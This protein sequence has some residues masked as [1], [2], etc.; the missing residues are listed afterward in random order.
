MSQATSG[1][2]AERL[3]VWTRGRAGFAVVLVYCLLAAAASAQDPTASSVAAASES[4][5]NRFVDEIWPIFQAH[6]HACHG[7]FYTLGGLS[8]YSADGIRSGSENGPVIEAGAPAESELFRRISLPEEDAG[9]MPQKAKR[10]APESIETIRVWIADGALLGD[11]VDG[12][13]LDD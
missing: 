5:G 7:S 13:S 10:L 1:I 11:F 3:F 4:T 12:D 2:A 6:C 9:R 8:L